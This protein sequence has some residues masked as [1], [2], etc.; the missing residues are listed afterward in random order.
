MPPLFFLSYARDDDEEDD[1]DKSTLV[2]SFFEDL[3]DKIRDITGE[4]PAADGS[5]IDTKI[6]LGALWEEHIHQ[7]VC[8]CK[9]FVALMS[10]SYFRRE[11]CGREW[12]IFETR[13]PNGNAGDKLVPIVW[14]PSV[15]V[16][17]LAARY[18]HT[19][20]DK[21]RAELRDALSDYQ[22]QGLKW[23]VQYRNEPQ[24]RVKYGLVVREIAKR[25]VAAAGGG[26]LP[27]LDPGAAKKIEARFA[28]PVAPRTLTVAEFDDDDDA[29]AYFLPVVGMR[30]QIK[31]DAIRERYADSRWNWQPFV[32][33]S[34]SKLG[35]TLASVATQAELRPLWLD[36]KDDLPRF[37]RA[38]ESR[39]RMVVVVVDA[40]STELQEYL[41]HA[42][43]LDESLFRNCVV[44]VVWSDDPNKVPEL[45]PL[46][47]ERALGRRAAE[48]L[49]EEVYDHAGFTKRLGELLRLLDQR[50][51]PLRT[52]TR[53][54]PP[55]D[56]GTL[57]TVSATT[58]RS[59]AP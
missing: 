12:A 33:Q 22:D 14:H 28:A 20:D 13:S 41:Q 36:F 48:H 6:P 43:Q 24:Y 32:P 31:R 40:W 26:E 30:A 46:V 38:A 8:D 58:T 21:N 47:R 1:G 25:V 17:E 3:H 39:G 54:L 5:F 44:V 4:R 42:Q 23:L 29:C 19:I 57:P 34:L 10:P 45:V 27:A 56:G 53:K 7:A 55:G 50:L 35:I 59:G 49:L 51:A 52:P 9:I 15:V 37:I 11:W 18:Q 16:P 2:R